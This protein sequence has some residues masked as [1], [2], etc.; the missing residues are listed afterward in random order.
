MG[1]IY[2]DKDGI[3]PPPHTKYFARNSVWSFSFV[4][5][6]TPLQLKA[7]AGMAYINAVLMVEKLTALTS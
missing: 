2:A 1:L 3:T 5:V 7:L 4:S 6:N